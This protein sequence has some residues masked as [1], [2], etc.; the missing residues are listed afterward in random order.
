MKSMTKFVVNEIFASINGEGTLSGELAIFIR[1]SG[2]NLRCSYCD[3]QYAQLPKIGNEMTVSAI[4]D[5]IAQ[6]KGINNITL[7][8]GEPLFRENIG[9]LLEELIKNGYLVNIE[10]N[11]SIALDNLINAPFSNKLIF[12]CDYKLA[13]SLEES[14]MKLANIKQLRQQ[15]VLKFVIG[16]NQDFIKIKQL[17]QNFKPQ[18]YI[19]LSAV[20]GKIKPAEIVEKLTEWAPN[21]DTSKMRVQLQ[22]HKYIWDPNL[23]GV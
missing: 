13:S 14:K 5:E 18:C 17:V 15:D 3:T 4:L 7:T 8:G 1:L 11:G 20:F 12:C 23:R 10:T 9:I 19:Y 16:D 2:C 6:Y 22:M 21:M